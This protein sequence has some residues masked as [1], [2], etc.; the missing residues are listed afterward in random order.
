MI[1]EL[2]TITIGSRIKVSYIKQSGVIK[3]FYPNNSLHSLWIN[4]SKEKLL[5]KLLIFIKVVVEYALGIHVGYAL[6]WVT[7]LYVGKTYVKHFEPVYLDDLSQLSSLLSRWESAP[8]IFAQNGAMIGVAAGMIAIALIHNKSRKECKDDQHTKHLCKFES[9]GY[10]VNN[11]Q[12]YLDLV[13]EPKYKCYFCGRT[14]NL[15][16]SLCNPTKL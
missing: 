16:E 8:D 6:G 9:Y 14:A 12:D 4:F 7:G 15:E 2:S 13:K 5:D 3:E 10:H 11:E 1:L